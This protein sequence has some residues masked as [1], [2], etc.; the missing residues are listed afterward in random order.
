[1]KGAAWAVVIAQWLSFALMAILARR[2]LGMDLVD[3]FRPRAEDWRSLA[4]GLRG[5]RG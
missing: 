1:M 4:S 5:L 3:V 2:N